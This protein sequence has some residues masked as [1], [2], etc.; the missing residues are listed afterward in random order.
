[1]KPFNT[2][3]L[4][5]A[6][7][8]ICVVIAGITIMSMQIGPQGAIFFLS[9]LAY[10]MSILIVGLFIAWLPVMRNHN[11]GFRIVDGRL[12]WQKNTNEIDVRHTRRIFWPLITLFFEL[13]GLFGHCNDLWPSLSTNILKV[14]SLVVTVALL[15]SWCIIVFVEDIRKTK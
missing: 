10:A 3:S 9:Y 1:M 5:V 6:F 11:W 8:A 4:I 7:L 14:V 13:F 12:K 2:F 15:L